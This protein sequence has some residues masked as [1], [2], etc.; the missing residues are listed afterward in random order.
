M[1]LTTEEKEGLLDSAVEVIKGLGGVEGVRDGL[2]EMHAAWQRMER[3][4]ET[5]LKTYPDKWVAMSKDGV[6]AVADSVEGVFAKVDD[7][8]LHRNAVN[9]RFIDTSPKTLIL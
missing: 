5:L 3:E 8:G 4:R 2:A 1:T 6:V 7:I 9:V